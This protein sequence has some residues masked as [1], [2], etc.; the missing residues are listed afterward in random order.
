M[1]P[2]GGQG[3]KALGGQQ[4]L[5]AISEHEGEEGE[6]ADEG[7]MGGADEDDVPQ[8][9]S[10]F[11]YQHTCGHMLVCDLQVCASHATHAQPH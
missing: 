1:A 8:A 9:F 7:P 3:V 10:H 5:G 11:T 2:K 4:P 6:A